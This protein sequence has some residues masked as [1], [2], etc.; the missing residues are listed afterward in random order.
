MQD[1][2]VTGLAVTPVKALR[3]RQVD[4][5]QLGRFGA[6]GDRAFYLID[7]SNRMINGK[8]YGGLQTVVADFDQDGGT[9]SLTFPDG[10]KV[11]DRV[12]YGDRVQTLF[13]SHPRRARLVEGPWSGALS[14]FFGAELRVVEDGSAVDRGRKA[15]VSLFSR[16]SLRRLAEVAESDPVDGRRFRMLIEI[17]GVARHQEDRWVGRRV[18]IGDA[19]LEMHG[20]VG[21]CMVTTRNPESGEVDFQTLHA[22][23]TY[24]RDEES[25]EP[26]PFGV[27]GEVLEGGVV[28]L[29]DPVALDAG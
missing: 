7:G 8:R 19:R 17:D 24:R 14:E 26:L 1:I 2:T 4:S 13:H 6:L 23:A 22:L 11:S 16:G 25:D 3:V 9:L 28:K 5:V 20:H 12:R 29:G 21:R 27:Y 18:R 15:G 10:A